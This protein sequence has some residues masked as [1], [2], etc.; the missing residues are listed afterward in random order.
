MVHL[1]FI[2]L[3]ALFRP[4]A[5]QLDE[6]R[7]PAASIMLENIVSAPVN[8][9]TN[10]QE[11]QIIHAT[12]VATDK[13]KDSGS[14]PPIVLLHGFDSSCLEFRKLM[15]ELQ[16]RNLEAYAIDILGCGFM[17]TSSARSVGIEA[18]RQLLYAF[19]Q[20]VLGERPM[21]LAGVSLGAAVIIDFH[22]K[23]PG[24]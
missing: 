19:W 4:H 11:D 17:D 5:K 3:A 15:P 14:L 7:D 6:I 16:E 18:K 13:S 1:V 8:I 21:L 22:D 2:S 12:F 9:A 20:E 23:Y 10:L 24:K